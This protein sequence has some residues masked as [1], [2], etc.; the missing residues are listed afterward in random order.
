MN[1]KTMKT[2]A[3]LTVLCL[4][5]LFFLIEK[6]AW[7]A[8][9]IQPA[10]QQALSNSVTTP[11]PS[12]PGASI[13][14]KSK[15]LSGQDAS[16]KT[17]TLNP[18]GT[19]A[20]CPLD[21]ST[22]PKGDIRDIRGPI[23]IPDPRLWVFYAL[24]GILLLFLAWALWKWLRKQKSLRSKTTFE[25]A[26]EELEK[27]KALMNPE[28]AERFSV[29]VSKTIRKY[30]ENR[31]DIKVTRKTTHEFITQVAAEPSSELNRHSE[32]LREFLDHC[33]LAKFA[34]HTFSQKEMAK[35]HQSAWRFV[36]ETR[37]QPKEN[38][39]A[40]SASPIKGNTKA[41]Q[42]IKDNISGKKRFFR[43]HLKGGF[44]WNI[45]KKAG[46][47]GF[48]STHPVVTAGGR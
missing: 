2:S 20:S 6:M 11:M 26:L 7:S 24:G 13:T 34:R 16:S 9:A 5:M 8:S 45:R 33:D 43:G 38:E 31:F 37:P 18:N 36:E 30:I 10:S 40:K 47:S 28:M 22:G 41:A 23:H 39:A 46:D 3:V 12:K 32:P 35:M 14:G 19:P 48:N 17:A 15:R 1:S 44:Q 21:L 42:T 29:M 27:A 25:I 4:L